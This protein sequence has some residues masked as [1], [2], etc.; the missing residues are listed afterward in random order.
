M[1]DRFDQLQFRYESWRL[2]KPALEKGSPGVKAERFRTITKSFGGAAPP[3]L[4]RRE[5]RQFRKLLAREEGLGREWRTNGCQKL[6][7]TPKKTK[8]A[9]QAAYSDRR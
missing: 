5:M 4:S 2:G 7:A 3:Q 8:H 6:R 1:S 9:R